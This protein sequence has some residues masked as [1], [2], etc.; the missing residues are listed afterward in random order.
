MAHS[1]RS[2]TLPY[3]APNNLL[4]AA[5]LMIS[6]MMWIASIVLGAM[7]Y[8]SPFALAAAA[9]FFFAATSRLFAVQHDNGHLSYFTSRRANVWVGVLLGA[10]TAH[11]FHTMRYNHNRH[12]AH[13]GNLDQMESHE[14][15]TWTVAQWRTA[16]FWQRLGY[17]LYRS[18]LAICLVG[19]I[20]I[21]LL[22]YRFPKNARKV[23]LWDCAVQNV[24]MGALWTAVYIFGGWPAFVTLIVGAIFAVCFATLII[25]SGHNHEETYWNPGDDVDF[26]EAS[27]RGASV[28]DLGPIF[29]FMIFNFSYHDLHHLNSKVPCYRLRACH[30]ALEHLISPTRLGWWD[31]FRTLRWNLWDEEKGRMVS[32]SDAPPLFAGASYAIPVTDQDG[33]DVA[34]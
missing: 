2:L 19:P 6:L 34:G 29:D 1:L 27:L 3:L 31:L 4:G 13:I 15:M 11:P 25:Y 7:F 32:F 26:E 14:V 16:T 21:I 17:R 23:G 30:K 10:F 18:P 24:L 20:A 9:V 22:R 12:H 8:P 28:L 33:R 5:H